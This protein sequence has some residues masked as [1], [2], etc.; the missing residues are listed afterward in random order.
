MWIS[1][2]GADP[3][4]AA[5]GCMQFPTHESRN[6]FKSD[7]SYPNSSFSHTHI[8]IPTD[9]LE[10]SLSTI[11]IIWVSHTIGTWAGAWDGCTR[12]GPITLYSK[13]VSSFKDHRRRVG[14]DESE[15]TGDHG[16]GSEPHCSRLVVLF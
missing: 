2:R 4:T 9:N 8:Y 11:A 13:A 14:Y 3:M 1:R 6:M 5:A 15:E 16:E 7:P 10:S 12:I